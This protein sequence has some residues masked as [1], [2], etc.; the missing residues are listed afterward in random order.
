MNIKIS[1]YLNQKFYYGWMIILIAGLSVFFSAPGQS[2]SISTFMI[3]YTSDFGLSKTLISSIYSIATICS[4][5]L[6]VFMGKA[7][8]KYGQRKMTVIVGIALAI[9]C[10]FNSYISNIVMIAISFFLL[11]YLGQGSLT[12]IPNSLTPQWFDKRR[13]LSISLM[14]LGGMIAN[15][16]VPVV[17]VY[18]IKL[19]SWQ[20]VWKLWSLAVMIF[21]VPL[22]FMLIV[23]KPEDIGTLP[24]NEQATDETDP[25]IKAENAWTLHEAIK[26][27]EFWFVGIISMIVPMITT[28]LVLHFFSIM[29]LKGISETQASFVIGLIALPGFI[30]PIVSGLIIDRFRS[31]HIITF[32]LICM[33]LTLLL[34]MNVNSVI[35]AVIFMLLYGLVTNIQSVTI[36]VIWPRYFGRKYLGSIRGAATIF[37][38]IG[39]ALG[40]I[41]FG[42]SYDLTGGYRAVLIVMMVIT[43][44]S[45]AMAVSIQKPIKSDLR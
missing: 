8:D 43:V 16:T 15:L 7:V 45:M 42:L 44:L 9:V 23:N 25:S 26:T 28:G 22:A 5:L 33:A 3:S 27:K 41:P 11:R 29:E 14:N 18:L 20:Y 30:M 2:Y 35:T 21:F 4:G 13:A 34:F 19:Y 32:T 24:D 12:L 6:L 36:S 1:K 10:F 39:S 38:V 31:K 40:P 37:M 17:N